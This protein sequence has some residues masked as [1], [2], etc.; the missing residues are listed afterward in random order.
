MEVRYVLPVDDIQAVELVC[1]KPD[2][3]GVLRVDLK[4]GPTGGFQ[5][6]PRCNAEWWGPRVNMT[7]PAVGLLEALAFYCE[8]DRD[9]DPPTVHLVYP[10][11]MRLENK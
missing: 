8:R 2:C 9:T 6:C 5:R 7:S 11:R 4:V 10:G 3:G 1:A